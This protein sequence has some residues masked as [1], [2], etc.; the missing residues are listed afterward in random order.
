M[1]LTQETF[2][3]P[4]TTEEYTVATAASLAHHFLRRDRAVGMLAYGQSN[5][6]IQPDRGERQ[7]M[8]I[9][10]TLAVLRASGEMALADL[11]H[12]ESHIFPRG[13]T[14]LAVTP[15]TNEN[16]VAAV[17][18]LTRRGLRVVTVLIDPES[19][20]GRQSAKPLVNLLR[21]NGLSCYLVQ[22]GDD[23]AAVLSG[24]G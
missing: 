9:L 3:L 15:T 22:R 11:L 13:T 17:Q 23:L 24:R 14:I 1:R 19:F 20:G 18:Q 12:L 5:E 4:D 16:W 6:I 2:K 7:R 21:A 10:E 8:R